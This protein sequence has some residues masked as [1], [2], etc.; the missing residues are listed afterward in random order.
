MVQKSRTFT[1]YMYI[2]FIPCHNRAVKH[3]QAGC[4]IIRLDRGIRL[5][6]VLFLDENI[7]CGYSLE[8]PCQ[9]ASYEYPQ[10][11]FSLGNKKNIAILV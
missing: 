3:F 1:I 4:I 8:A 10:H 9:G 5:I 7:H 11:M 6:V 2:V